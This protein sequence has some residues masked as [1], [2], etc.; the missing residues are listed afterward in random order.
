MSM[1]D[2]EKN[3]ARKH[4][5]EQIGREEW[6]LEVFRRHVAHDGFQGGKIIVVHTDESQSV[7]PIY[8]TDDMQEVLDLA[9]ALCEK[10]CEGM[11]AQLKRLG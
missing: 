10:R 8:P 1:T 4:L 9:Q 5:Y 6:N 7:Y 2:V 11:L 3:I